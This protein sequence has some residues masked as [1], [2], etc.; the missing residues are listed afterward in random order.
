MSKNNN[1]VSLTLL[2]GYTDRDGNLHREVVFGKRLTAG[3]MMNLDYDPQAQ[4]PV[5]Y[6]ELTRRLMIT[7]FG[8]LS[9]PP[10][11]PVMLALDT[12]DRDDLQ[13]AQQKF[14]QGSDNRTGEYRTDDNEVKLPFGFVVEGVEYNVVKFGNRL[15][16][17]DEAEAAEFPDGL[18]PTL[19][20]IG[21]QISKI[22]TEDGMLSID[23]Q[24]DLERFESLDAVSIGFL[25]VGAELFRQSFRLKRE[26]NA[27]KNENDI[28][29][30]EGDGNERKRSGESTD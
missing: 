14:L 8:T 4:N 25:R 5:H 1:E 23:G 10:A 3:D 20:L 12:I 24:V 13:A 9:M 18:K 27:G 16:V 17:K 2:G 29:H 28:F 7:K 21:K 19:F 22:S 6:V 30:N 26:E 15:S 11:L